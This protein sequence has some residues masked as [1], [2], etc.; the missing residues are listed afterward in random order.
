MF[1]ANHFRKCER[2]FEREERMREKEE[3][4]NEGRERGERMRDNI[5]DESRLIFEARELE[6]FKKIL[7]R[8]ALFFK[9]ARSPT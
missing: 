5:F 8:A 7:R 1:S 6:F 2:D 4:N 3:R 9:S